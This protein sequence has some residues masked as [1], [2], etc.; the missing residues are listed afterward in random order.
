M[1]KKLKIALTFIFNNNFS[2]YMTHKVRTFYK[3][4]YNPK[5]SRPSFTFKLVASRKK[6]QIY[7]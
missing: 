5:W 1:D 4:F 2:D 3:L 6:L 7:S